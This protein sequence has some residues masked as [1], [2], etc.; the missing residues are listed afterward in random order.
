M[1]AGAA[2]FVMLICIGI[3]IPWGAQAAPASAHGDVSQR[4]E[5][6]RQRFP[7]G[8]FFTV[9]G[10]SCTHSSR[11]SCH[12]CSLHGVMARLGY[13]SSDTLRQSWTC[14]AFARYAFWWIFGISHDVYAYQNIV[15]WG[16]R[17][18]P[19][20]Y[21]LPGDL[22]IWN[23]S[24][25]YP[26]TPTQHMAI[27][28]GNG[29]FFDSNSGGGGSTA[30]I[31][32]GTALTSLG[33]PSMVLRANNYEDV[34]GGNTRSI[35]SYESYIAYEAYNIYEAGISEIVDYIPVPYNSIV[36]IFTLPYP[37]G[38]ITVEL[39]RDS[40]DGEI[41]E[42]RIADVPTGDFNYIVTTGFMD[43]EPGNYSLVFYQ[44]GHTSF[45]INNVIIPDEGG[46]VQLHQDPRFPRRLPI[47][48]G[49]ITG[50]GQ[51]N[52]HDLALMMQNWMSDYENADFTRSGQINIVDLNYLLLNWMAESVVVD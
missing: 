11:G 44:P 12:N 50:S 51:V 43:V 14:V 27:Y 6:L 38:Y 18:I 35:P 16:T 28:L 33:A 37:V 8:S 29:L 25:S 23:G 4:I 22:F 15:P 32:Y 34:N 31:T 19:R 30:N 36:T 17:S 5:Q 48:P 45:T 42:T 39:R 21:A 7:D 2:V 3:F 20:A 49:N 1:I 40:A 9:S 13:P 47:F 24:N 26:F 41:V 10:A 46:I 52:V